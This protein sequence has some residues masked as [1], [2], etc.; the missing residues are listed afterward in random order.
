MTDTID[1]Q[2]IMREIRERIRNGSASLDL[3][4][5]GSAAFRA[6]RQ[7]VQAVEEASRSLKSAQAL[8][9]QLPPQPPTM[10]G[11]IG[12]LLTKAVRRALFWYTPQLQSFHAGVVRGM[13]Q[14]TAAL[15]AGASANQHTQELVESLSGQVAKLS[16]EVDRLNRRL[17]AEA[18]ARKRLQQALRVELEARGAPS[19]LRDNSQDR[20]EAARKVAAT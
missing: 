15:T 17:K 9:G 18:L 16:A 6:Q 1:V 3:Q 14:Q 8:F 19:L 2:K 5:N 10:R 4:R 12:S 20:Q 7:A 11:R 13:E